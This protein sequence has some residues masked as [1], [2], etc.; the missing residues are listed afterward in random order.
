MKKSL[1]LSMLCC[2]LVLSG[3]N[4][5]K[6]NT[7]GGMAIYG[8]D[9]RLDMY[10]VKNKDVLKNAEA[11]MSMWDKLDVIPNRDGTYSL[12][13][14]TFGYSYS[15]HRDELFY[16]QQ[17]GAS[18]TGF[19]VAPDV[20][21]TAG[22]CINSTNYKSRVFVFGYKMQS[23]SYLETKKITSDKVYFVKKVLG[24]KL[25]K[26][27][28]SDFAVIQLDRPVKGVTPLKVSKKRVKTSQYVYL[29]GHPCGLP[30]KFAP[31]GKVVSSWRT[32]YFIAT[33]DAFGGNS[34]SPVFNADHEVV[35]ILVRGEPDFE[36]YQGRRRVKKGSFGESITNASQWIEYIPK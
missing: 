10:E 9:D 30:L 26:S 31:N 23:K 16:S 33:V 7:S 19:L 20:V 13:T 15:L 24:W 35:G 2:L 14:S 29:M 32:A 18:C 22:H 12:R 5:F 8:D 27:S 34:G 25:D 36:I 28:G 4:L 6:P 11:V 1:I 17:I 21:V 3:C